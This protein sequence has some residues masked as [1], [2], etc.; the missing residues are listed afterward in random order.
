MSGPRLTARFRSWLSSSSTLAAFR[1]PGYPAMWLSGASGAF[2][3]SSN[4][5]AVG[6]ITLEVSG[7]SLAVGATFAARLAPAL[8]VGIPIGALVDRLDRRRVL[9]AGNLAGIATA[10]LLAGL[11][12][13]GRLDLPLILV[14]SLGLGMLDTLR[15]TASQS[16]AFDLAGPSGATNAIALSNLGGQLLGSVGSIAGGLVLQHVGSAAAFGMA[17][18]PA[19]IAATSLALS[20]GHAARTRAATRLS[21][22]ASRSTTLLFRNRLVALITLVVILG[23]VLGFSSI[24]LRPAFARDILHVDAAGLGAMNAAGAIGG[25]AGLLL[26]ARVGISGRAGILLLGATAG[27]GLC[28]VAFSFSTIYLVSLVLLMG[29]G[30]TASAL[31]TLGQALIQRSVGDHERGAAMG[32]WF[33]AIGFGPFGHVGI[34]AAAAVIGVPLAL[35][36]SGGGLLVAALALTT[37]RQLREL[38]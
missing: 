35:G 8:I 31:D 25:V 36:L 37:V 22:S 5:V 10:L 23:E 20:S 14:L 33:F 2:A 26:L 4:L 27:F 30:L 15:G 29:V 9:I 12:A 6:W 28:L 38:K 13:A 16:Y 17:A 32:T 18:I 19:A 24:T 34:G 3:W 21:P 1:L 7:S 11:A